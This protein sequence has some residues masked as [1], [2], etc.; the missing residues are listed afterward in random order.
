[1]GKKPQSS[2]RAKTGNKSA[3]L[4]KLEKRFAQFRAEHPRGTRVPVELREA[5][6]AALR[7]GTAPGDLYRTC[8]I[9]WGQLEAWKSGHKPDRRRR[10]R[11]EEVRVFSVVDA[12]PVVR[13]APVDSDVQD[14]ELRLGRWSV[15]V[16]LAEPSEV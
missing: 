11:E 10:N 9:S 3:V 16:R 5:T 8:G 14:L 2:R 7:A 12:E 6:L 1:M 15:R 4:D 13:Q